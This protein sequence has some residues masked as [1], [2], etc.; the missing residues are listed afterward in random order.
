MVSFSCVAS[1]KFSSRAFSNLLKILFLR[2]LWSIYS[3][4]F[5]D[6]VLGLLGFYLF[7]YLW[8]DNCSY[9]HT[10]QHVCLLDRPSSWAIMPDVLC[11]KIPTLMLQPPLS[12]FVYVVISCHAVFLYHCLYCFGLR[13]KRDRG[14]NNLLGFRHPCRK[15][16]IKLVF[17]VL[18][19]FD[20]CFIC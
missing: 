1:L 19:H 16:S 12:L 3:K 4:G 13:S 17:K 2:S 10:V 7:I 5:L 9:L 14:K 11:L 18:K 15:H 6:L 8:A 20:F